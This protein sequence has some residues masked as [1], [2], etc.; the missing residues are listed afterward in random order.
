MQISL[1]QDNEITTLLD[2]LIDTGADAVL[3]SD[4]LAEQLG[5]DLSEHEGRLLMPSAV[6]R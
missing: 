6:A 3:A 4:L 5:I 2:G 1:A